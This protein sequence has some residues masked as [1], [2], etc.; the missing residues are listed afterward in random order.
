MTSI[1]FMAANC[2]ICGADIR[3]DVVEL[4]L[5]IGDCEDVGDVD[6]PNCDAELTVELMAMFQIS[7]R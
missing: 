4:N 1:S 7:D 2:P 3:M 5:G 6:C